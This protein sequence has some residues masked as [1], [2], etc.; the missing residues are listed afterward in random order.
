[1]SRACDRHGVTWPRRSAWRVFF[2]GDPLRLRALNAPGSRG[3]RG[4]AFA[5]GAVADAILAHLRERVALPGG[6]A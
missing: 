3:R 5:R 4:A 1:M 6:A 2:E